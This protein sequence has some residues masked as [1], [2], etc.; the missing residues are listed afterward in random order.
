MLFCSAP[1]SPDGR[2]PRRPRRR[3]SS[4]GVRLRHLAT[5]LRDRGPPGRG[6]SAAGRVGTGEPERA[7]GEASPGR[8]CR[9]GVQGVEAPTAM[10]APGL[11]RGLE[12]SNNMATREPADPARS[13]RR[14]RPEPLRSDGQHPRPHLLEERDAGHP[15]LRDQ[16][17]LR[18]GRTALRG[19]Q[20]GDPIVVYDPLADRWLLSQLCGE[21]TAGLEHQLIAISTSSDPTGT[22]F[23]YDFVLPNDKA[24]DYPHFGVWP[25]AYYMTNNQFLANSNV[26]DGGGAYA[27]DRAKMLAGDPTATYIYFDLATIDPEV[28]GELPSD[29]DGLTLPPAGTPNLFFD[30][31]ATNSAL[32]PTRCGSSSSTRTSRTLPPRRSPRCRTSRSRPSIPATRQP[33][34]HRAAASG[35]LHRLPRL[36]GLPD[37]APHRLSPPLR[38][39]GVDR[40]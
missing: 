14:R 7:E 26:F 37:D 24:N 29:L 31:R 12:R 1:S 38:R 11:L 6:L 8:V 40:R 2:E 5:R 23:V 17:R 18:R 9:R 34:L 13:G 21:T 25:D 10:P 33:R 16:R 20:R 27:F 36:A 30:I 35:D 22:Y 4:D 19:H 32:P 39:R 3:R 15:L 28:G